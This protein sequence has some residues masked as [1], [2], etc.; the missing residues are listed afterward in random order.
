MTDSEYPLHVCVIHEFKK[1]YPA[2]M[3]I[4]G[5]CFVFVAIIAILCFGLDYIQKI[6]NIIAGYLISIPWYFTLIVF[7]VVMCPLTYSII[8][9]LKRRYAADNDLKEL[10]L[11]CI[12][13]S[14]LLIA[15]LSV[16]LMSVFLLVFAVSLL[17]F[18]LWML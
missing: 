5:I 8:I 18:D 2:W 17:L 12:I 1:I 16:A 6:C 9:C 14:A 13:I 7:I 10:C 4:V 15:I 11:V 3:K